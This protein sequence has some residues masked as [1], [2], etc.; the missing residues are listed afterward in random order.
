MKKLIINFS[1]FLLFLLISIIV[2]LS[3]I[4]FETNKFNKLISDKTSQAKN[5]YLKLDT[6][7]FKINLRELNLFL[8]TKKPEIK[9]V[10]IF[11]NDR[12]SYLFF[13]NVFIK[14]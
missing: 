10:P 8:D 14:T 6:I 12:T 4:G 2:I 9:A 7:K 3:T 13:F 1:L 5:I 11:D